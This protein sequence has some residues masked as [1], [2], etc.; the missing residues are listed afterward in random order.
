MTKPRKKYRPRTPR[1]PMMP[2]TRADIAL[3]LHAAVETLIA[4]P[5]VESYNALSLQFVTLGRV[6]GKQDFMERAKR[7]ML[8][9]F[10]RFERVDKIG[11]SPD[12][13]QALRATCVAM[14]SAIG[15]VSVDAMLA[16]EIKTA[17]WCR[18]NGV[19]A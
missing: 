3:A 2:E 10:A 14:D 13:A 19:A 9:V 18:E 1:V 4:A 12:E 8:D 15:L 6:L 11:V 5:G 16:A 17:K 7:A